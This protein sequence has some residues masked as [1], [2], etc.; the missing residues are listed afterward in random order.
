MGGR[1]KLESDDGNQQQH[2]EENLHG[3]ER[4]LEEKRLG[5]GGGG[6][7]KADPNGVGGGKWNRFHREREKKHARDHR[8]QHDR[9]RAETRKAIGVFQA[10]APDGF[11][12]AGDEQINPRQHTVLFSPRGLERQ[13]LIESMM[14][15]VLSILLRAQGG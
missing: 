1:G 14:V 13:A 2:E 6:D 8:D 12:D 5:E 15:S 4:L 3:G 10:Y 11:E 9:G 7:A